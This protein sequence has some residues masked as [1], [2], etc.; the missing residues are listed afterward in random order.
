[1][2][3]A[4]ATIALLDEETQAFLA[5]PIFPVTTELQNEGTSYVFLVGATQP[6]PERFSVLIGEIVHQLRSSLDHLFAALILQNGRPVDHKDSFPI[7]DSVQRYKRACSLGM[8]DKVSATARAII[9]KAQPCFAS[10]TPLDTIL[11]AVR[12]LNNAD[13]HRM[14]VVLNSTGAIGRNI[15]IGAPGKLLLDIT[16]K[17]VSIIGFGDPKP[18]TIDQVPVEVFR[19]MLGSPVSDFEA[20]IE[21]TP[22]LVFERCGLAK[23][24]SVPKIMPILAAGIQHTIDLFSHEFDADAF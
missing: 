22:Q 20:R 6:V 23:Q 12:D 2:E 21:L 15:D 10:S 7:F 16:G 17:P 9:E 18:V 4:S 14:L 8:L 5:S 13:K 1:M 19:I 3:R 24:M 11:C